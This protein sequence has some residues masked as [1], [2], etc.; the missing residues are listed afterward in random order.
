MDRQAAALLHPWIAMCAHPQGG[1]RRAPNLSLHTHAEAR[2]PPRPRACSLVDEPVTDLTGQEDVW[3]QPQGLL[4][5]QV[6]QGAVQVAQ[7][8]V[9]AKGH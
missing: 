9:S 6:A 5:Q 8:E 2:A 4:V 1:T 3:M 7:A